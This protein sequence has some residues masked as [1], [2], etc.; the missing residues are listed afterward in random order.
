[1]SKLIFL[2]IALALIACSNNEKNP[3]ET[4]FK[5]DPKTIIESVYDASSDSEAP[6]TKIIYS[7]KNR[8]MTK[9]VVRINTTG[10]IIRGENKNFG[11]KKTDTG[12]NMYVYDVLGKGALWA[13]SNLEGTTQSFYFGK[14]FDSQPIYTKV[15]IED[16]AYY[17]DYT[18]RR[19]NDTVW[20]ADDYRLTHY[21]VS[22]GS[23]FDWERER[24]DPFFSGYLP[25]Y[26]MW[27]YD[28]TYIVKKDNYNNPLILSNPPLY[29]EYEYEYY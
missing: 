18:S 9:K 13:S 19:G 11:Y 2:T 14:T 28:T 8:L 7:Y 6:R 27:I 5:G 24:E 1:M 10:R 25:G 16:N 21:K 15:K 22:G 3:F 17:L 23:P 12:Y 26:E 20:L 4:S 29:Y